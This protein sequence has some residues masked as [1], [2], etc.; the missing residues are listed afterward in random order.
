MDNSHQI[1]NIQNQIAQEQ[2]RHRNRMQA[3][4]KSL[5][6]ARQANETVSLYRKMYEKFDKQGMTTAQ[7]IR[8]LDI[9]MSEYRH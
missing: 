6:N 2:T 1:V 5:E 4:K 8:C 7:I 3:L 9:L